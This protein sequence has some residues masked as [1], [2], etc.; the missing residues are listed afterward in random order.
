MNNYTFIEEYKKVREWQKV[1]GII[2]PW[3][4][5]ADESEGGPSEILAKS[6]FLNWA[7]MVLNKK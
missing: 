2:H 7:S 3:G 4:R 6:H 1:Q 5:Q